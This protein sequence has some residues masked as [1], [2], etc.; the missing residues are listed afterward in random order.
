MFRTTPFTNLLLLQTL[1]LSKLR[2]QPL[3]PNLRLQKLRRL[4]L[5][6]AI[7]NPQNCLL[8]VVGF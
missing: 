6:Q 5:S 7:A 4:P 1:Q 2:S 8:L 3:T